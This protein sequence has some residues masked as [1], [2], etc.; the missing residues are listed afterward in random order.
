[1]VKRL[2]YFY[3]GKNKILMFETNLTIDNKVADV[4]H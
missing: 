2:D 1:M 4:N 3:A